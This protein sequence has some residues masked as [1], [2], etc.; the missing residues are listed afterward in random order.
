[1]ETVV[2]GGNCCPVLSRSRLDEFLYD[3][4]GEVSRVTVIMEGELWVLFSY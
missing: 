1:M 3:T 2:A 4:G